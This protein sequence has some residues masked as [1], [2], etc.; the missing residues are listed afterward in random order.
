MP[1]DFPLQKIIYPKLKIH[2]ERDFEESKIYLAFLS[3][4][5]VQLFTSIFFW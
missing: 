1:L 3:L 4:R 2:M 5:D